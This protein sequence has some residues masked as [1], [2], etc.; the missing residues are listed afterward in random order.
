MK[1]PK[2]Y[3]LK[4]R[5]LSICKNG[6]RAKSAIKRSSAATGVKY[7][8]FTVTA[9]N[10]AASTPA[11]SQTFSPARNTAN[12]ATTAMQELVSTTTTTA[13]PKDA[14]FAACS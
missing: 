1:T 5:N 13:M 9:K 10:T 2:D 7:L 4:E 14:P 12:F 6:V 11:I 3:P 8:L